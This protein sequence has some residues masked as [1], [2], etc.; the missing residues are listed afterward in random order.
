MCWFWLLLC[1]IVIFVALAGIGA[2]KRRSMAL[3]AAAKA[4]RM[5]YSPGD[6]LDLT[7]KYALVSAFNR[8]TGGHAYNTIHGTRKGFH[9][10]VVDYEYTEGAG[11]KN[12]HT[13][14]LTYCIITV[15]KQL[16]DLQLRPENFLDTIKSWAGVVDIDFESK[17]FSDAFY[18]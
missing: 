17:E 7:F 6:P 14:T 16:P 10:V 11:M 8:G 18:V 5:K 4:L 2:P 15:D 1:A 3:A 9:T 12:S 13:A